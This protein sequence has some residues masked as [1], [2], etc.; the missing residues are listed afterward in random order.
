MWCKQP[1]CT[2]IHTKGQSICF[3]S[4]LPRSCVLFLFRV[5]YVSLV[6]SSVSFTITQ[7]NKQNHFHHFT[8][9]RIFVCLSARPPIM[10]IFLSQ[11][12]A[13]EV[14]ITVLIACSTFFGHHYAHHQELK[15]IIQLYGLQDAAAFCKPDTEPSASHQT[16]N[17]KTTAPNTADSN[18]CIILLSS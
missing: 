9:A 1:F 13:T 3:L 4:F 18:H 10:Y 11:L 5:H 17:L 15:S 8:L 16:S 2:T 6:L 7:N 14:F 12:D